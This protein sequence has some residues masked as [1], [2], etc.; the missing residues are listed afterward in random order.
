MNEA[1]PCPNTGSVGGTNPTGGC[2]PPDVSPSSLAATKKQ[3]RN[4]HFGLGQHT[5][6]WPDGGCELLAQIGAA[7]AAGDRDKVLALA[8]QLAG[9][10]DAQTGV[11]E[12]LL[13][14]P[15]VAFKLDCSTRTVWRLVA[16]QELAAPI[17]VGGNARWFRKDIGVYMAGAT[18]ERG[19]GRR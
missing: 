17:H 8:R 12:D 2:A 14:L 9:T 18:A 11:D 15:E 1:P 10:T 5:G 3:R 7:A 6:V 16:R 19:K 13:P 4:A